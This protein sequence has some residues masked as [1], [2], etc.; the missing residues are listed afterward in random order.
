ML[1]ACYFIDYLNIYQDEI[2]HNSKSAKFILLKWYA[3]NV[4]VNEIVGYES[5][6]QKHFGRVQVWRLLLQL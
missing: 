6:R 1:D 2:Y 4:I 3:N 5:N